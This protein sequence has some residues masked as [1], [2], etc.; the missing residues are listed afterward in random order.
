MSAAAPAA[1]S[2]TPRPAERFAGRL[3]GKIRAVHAAVEQSEPYRV[4]ADPASDPGL[5]AC[6]LKY[7]LLEV[8]SYGPHITEAT[9]TAIGR[10]P[11]D[12]PDLMRPMLLHDLEEVNHGEM[13]LVDYVKL[14]GSETWARSRR[15]TPAAFAVGAVCRMLAERES[16]FTY[17][18]YMY[19][20][21]GLTPLLAE[22]ALAFLR[23]RAIAVSARHFLDFHAREDIGHVRRL[24]KLI[25]RVVRDYPEAAAA[26]DYG[27]DCFRCVYPLPVWAAALDHAREECERANS[28][29]SAEVQR[30]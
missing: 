4:L 19:L 7:V 14:G 2:A 11:K 16:P 3:D 28:L 22:R 13:A 25:V 8:F 15:R 5:V 27:F 6:L 1:A 10:L 29:C 30:P 23:A 21:E 24:R 12:R 26:I 18:G 20:L 17:L 9:F